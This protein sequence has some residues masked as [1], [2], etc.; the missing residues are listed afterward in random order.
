MKTARLFPVN[1]Q[2]RSH[3]GAKDRYEWRVTHKAV[4]ITSLYTVTA[5]QLLQFPNP[6][7]NK[8]ASLF[9]YASDPQGSWVQIPCGR[10]EFHHQRHT[11]WYVQEI[12]SDL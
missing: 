12:L 8:A 7:E 5:A 11:R 9:V 4:C 10:I 2:L 1:M 3:V 6:R